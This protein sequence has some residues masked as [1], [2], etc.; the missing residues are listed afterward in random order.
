M[1]IPTTDSI[2][3]LADF[4]DTHSVTDFDDQLEE[5][6]EPVFGRQ[7]AHTVR[8]PFSAEERQAVRRIAASR[9]LQEAA[10]IREWV[11]EKLHTG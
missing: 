7:L 8:V 6:S 10:L 5:V 3:V 1:R 11:K 4:W 2:Q 9:G